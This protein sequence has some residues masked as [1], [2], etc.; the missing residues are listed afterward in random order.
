LRE[1]GQLWVKK[2]HWKVQYKIL[3]MELN[4]ATM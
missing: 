3:G 2:K 1:V 4:K